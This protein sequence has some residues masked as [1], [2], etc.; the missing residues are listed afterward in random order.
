MSDWDAARYHRLFN[1]QLAWGRTVAARLEPAPGERDI[2][3]RLTVEIAA[4]PAILVGGLDW[5]AAM[6]E[7]GRYAGRGETRN[8]PKNTE[9][10]RDEG[11]DGHRWLNW[12]LNMYG[13]RHGS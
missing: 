11:L 9:D 7:H 2:T 6:L 3:G 5:S 4:T 13:R 10:R 12:R 1:P 8:T